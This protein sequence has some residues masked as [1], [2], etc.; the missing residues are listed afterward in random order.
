MLETLRFQNGIRPS[1]QVQVSGTVLPT[2]TNFAAV[3]STLV[4]EPADRT[5]FP[6]TL[7]FK[8][9]A[10]RWVNSTKKIMVPRILRYLK[11][12]R[13]IWAVL[14]ITPDAHRLSVSK[15][16]N[17]K[18]NSV[19]FSEISICVPFYIDIMLAVTRRLP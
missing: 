1:L 5:S 12:L 6:H 11:I 16:Q 15:P 13:D 10:E 19:R 18:L 8:F 3:C 14:S 17:L 9:S 2:V 7:R 4:P